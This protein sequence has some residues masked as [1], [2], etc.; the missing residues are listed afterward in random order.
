MCEFVC[1]CVCVPA[2]AAQIPT[3]LHF[4]HLHLLLP[5]HFILSC[6]NHSIFCS[7]YLPAAYRRWDTISKHL[8]LCSH[9]FTEM[10]KFLFLLLLDRKLKQEGG[11]I[12]KGNE[13]Q[14]M[15]WGNPEPQDWNLQYSASTY[16][17]S[18]ISS[19][20]TVTL[21]TRM[22]LTRSQLQN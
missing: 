20:L 21:K 14:E 18:T 17:F 11:E 13:T 4:R 5:T 6:G 2:L 22:S 7:H 3:L 1:L 15:V 16:Q 12:V 9:L 8:C 10:P 19:S